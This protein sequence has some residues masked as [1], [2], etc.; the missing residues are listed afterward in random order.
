MLT[1]AETGISGSIEYLTVLL[2][3]TN[4]ITLVILSKFLFGTKITVNIGYL[5]INGY[6]PGYPGSNQV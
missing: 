4:D 1:K 2:Q 3:K 5:E 6:P